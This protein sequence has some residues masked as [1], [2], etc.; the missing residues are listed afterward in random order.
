M[1]NLSLALFALLFSSELTQATRLNVQPGH[2]PHQ[3]GALKSKGLHD[4]KLDDLLGAWFTIIHDKSV[5]AVMG[6]IGTHYQVE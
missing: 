6:C 3:P 5:P 1:K 2:C 4:K